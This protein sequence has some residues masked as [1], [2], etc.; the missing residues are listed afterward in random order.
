MRFFRS[1]L[2]RKSEEERKKNARETRRKTR[3]KKAVHKNE[4]GR[5]ISRTSLASISISTTTTMMMMMRVSV[6][7]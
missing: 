7:Y 2:N 6:Y 5:N 4:K 1:P 3:R